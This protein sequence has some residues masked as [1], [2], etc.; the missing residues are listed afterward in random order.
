MKVSQNTVLREVIAW[1]ICDNWC[2]TIYLAESEETTLRDCY[3]IV[4]NNGL[5]NSNDVIIVLAEDA[6]NGTVYM[7]GNHGSYW[8][9]H[10]T[11]KGYA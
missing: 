11:L 3:N 10:G 4:A 6:L 9:E 8:E 5:L 1:I 7:Y 2:R